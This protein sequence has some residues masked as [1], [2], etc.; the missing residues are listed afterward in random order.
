METEE[1]AERNNNKRGSKERWEKTLERGKEKERVREEKI[2]RTIGEK[3]E[4]ER[5]THDEKK[6]R[7][8]MREW[9]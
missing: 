9:G 7:E 6:G 1:E 3:G 5:V 4:S 2:R 8:G